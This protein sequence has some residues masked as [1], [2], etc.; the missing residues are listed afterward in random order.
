MEQS[1]NNAAAFKL[2]NI[3]NGRLGSLSLPRDLT[4][5]GTKTNKKIYKPNLNVVRNKDKVKE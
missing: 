1:R 4:L 5:G 2:N 3:V